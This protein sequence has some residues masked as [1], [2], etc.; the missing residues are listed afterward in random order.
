MNLAVHI[1]HNIAADLTLPLSKSIANRELLINALTASPPPPLARGRGGAFSSVTPQVCLNKGEAGVAPDDIVVMRRGMAAGDGGIIDVGGAGTAMRFLTAY[2]ATR[3]G[4][5]VTI[6]G[7]D[8]LC[9]RPISP[10]VN[11]LRQMGAD[12]DYMGCEQCAPLRIAGRRLHGGHV[13]M[14]GDVSSQFASALL[15]IGPAVGGLELELTG[16]IVSRPY[17]DMT[18]ALMERHGVKV[19]C[20]GQTF[21]VPADHYLPTPSSD[22]GDWSAASFWLAL[23]ALLPQARITLHGLVRDSVQGDRRILTLLEQMGMAAHWDD[24]G[25][26]T[27]D[28]S[29]AACCCCSTFADLNGTPDMAPVLVVLLCLLGRPFRLTGLRTLRDKESD[30]REALRQELAKLGYAIT[31]EGDDAISWHFATCPAQE[32]P[33]IDPHGDHRIAMALALAAVRH[34]GLTIAHAEVVSKSYPDFWKHLKL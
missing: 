32:Q 23:Q 29:H 16:D 7:N 26:I 34:P 5:T 11:V 17:I 27:A 10:L 30:R 18:I 2:W 24:D 14:R 20:D 8:R 12:I 19:Q 25:T 13:T 1:P 9:K 31:L 3:E 28:M 6:T 4:Y 33:V 21:I 15:M 22:E